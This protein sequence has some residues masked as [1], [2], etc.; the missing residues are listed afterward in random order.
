MY[1]ELSI[2]FVFIT[3]ISGHKLHRNTE[4]NYS[5]QFVGAIVSDGKGLDQLACQEGWK[6]CKEEEE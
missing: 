3:C 4:I 5:F 2:N 6:K 1:H